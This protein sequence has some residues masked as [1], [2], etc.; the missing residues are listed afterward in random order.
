M[1]IAVGVCVCCARAAQMNVSDAFRKARPNGFVGNGVVNGNGLFVAA[2]D[3]VVGIGGVVGVVAA[4]V[5]VVVIG[6][7]SIRSSTTT[8]ALAPLAT[9]AASAGGGTGIGKYIAPLMNTP[10]DDD[11][12]V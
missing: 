2:D 10:G 4:V 12:V 9:P 6:S 3:V 5:V 7:A 1:F 8:S 11:G